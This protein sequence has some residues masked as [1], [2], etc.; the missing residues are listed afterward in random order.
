[1]GP[2]KKK[3]ANKLKIVVKIINKCVSQYICV[4]GGY[5]LCPRCKGEHMFRFD[6]NMVCPSRGDNNI[7][8]KCGK[9]NGFGYVDWAANACQR[10]DEEDVTVFIPFEI[11]NK[12]NLETASWVFYKYL[13]AEPL[14]ELGKHFEFNNNYCEGSVIEFGRY[15][16]QYKKNR[17]R[18]KKFLEKYFDELRKD[19]L[20]STKI[21]S[22][23]PQRSACKTCYFNPFDIDHEKRSDDI[24]IK[25]CGNCYGNGYLLKKDTKIIRD[26][27]AVLDNLDYTDKENILPAIIETADRLRNE[28]TLKPGKRKIANY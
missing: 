21:S 22:V 28:F 19:F 2:G 18:R 8:Y 23:P 17:D 3:D 6:K 26:Y 4:P 25:V 1:L 7:L 9:C 11:L 20:E 14:Q 27:V 12:P 24:K 16:L 13:F 15:F 5:N 10:K